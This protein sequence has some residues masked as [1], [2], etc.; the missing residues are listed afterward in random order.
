MVCRVYITSPN[1]W[2]EFLQNPHPS[3]SHQA[4]MPRGDC[5][6]VMFG[7]TH[8][9]TALPEVS[10]A[11]LLT[12]ES[13]KAAA[14]SDQARC[15]AVDSSIAYKYNFGKCNFMQVGVLKAGIISSNSSNTC[16]AENQSPGVLQAVDRLCPSRA[17][18]Q[19][20]WNRQLEVGRIVSIG[21]Y[22][23]Q[24]IITTQTFRSLIL[25]VHSWC[26]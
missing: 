20:P 8:A 1:S 23:L 2:T 24:T 21:S 22:H 14:C 6:A 3:I 13:T 25:Y 10:Q 16:N 17:P 18:T 11:N 5:P 15:I 9:V 19:E 7:F 4:C 26:S 12:L